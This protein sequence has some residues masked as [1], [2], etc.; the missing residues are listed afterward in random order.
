M[1]S[2]G[3]IRGAASVPDSIFWVQGDK[4]ALVLA[5]GA[6]QQSKAPSAEFRVV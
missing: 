1:G 3:R 4:G 2:D 6:L 5:S